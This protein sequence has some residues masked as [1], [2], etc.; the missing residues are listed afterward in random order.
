MRLSRCTTF[1]VVAVLSFGLVAVDSAAAQTSPLQTPAELAKAIARTIDAGTLKTPDGPISFVSATAH[2]NTVEVRFT[3]RN[4]DMFARAKANTEMQ[5][6][7]LTRYYCDASRV[8]ALNTGV[9]IHQVIAGPD[10]R[11]SIEFTIDKSACAA[12][13]APPKLA[14]AKTLAAMA[15]TVAQTLNT[16]S[17][18]SQPKPNNPFHFDTATGHDGVVEVHYNIIDTSVA[19]NAKANSG[20][21]VGILKGYF[22]GGYGDD[23]RRGLSFHL[24]FTLVDGSP[25]IDFPIDRSSCG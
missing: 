24:A 25:V 11:D 4:A 8:T 5:R 9:V 6:V 17:K 1:A 10:N 12:L 23:I 13:A 20:P 14:D 18:S 16:E 22:C 7:A 3:T 19:Q 15:Q 2:D 21:L